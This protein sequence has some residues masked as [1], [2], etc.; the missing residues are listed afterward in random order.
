M[1]SRMSSRV[2][3][4][5]W[6]SKTRAMSAGCARRGRASRRPGR[7]ANPQCRTA[8]AGGSPSPGRSPGRAYRRSRADPTRPSPRRRGRTAAVRRIERLRNVG[9]DSGRHVG[10][11]ADQFRRRLQ[12]HL[13]RNGVPQSPPCATNRVYPR[14][15]ISTVQARAMRMG[16]QPVAA[17]LPENPWPG[18]EG[19]TTSKASSALPP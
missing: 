13:L 17:G 1:L 12:R 3:P 4:S 9:R 5:D 6:P 7:P 16:S 15:F 8:S 18:S 19:M 10:V 14:R 2:R 11:D